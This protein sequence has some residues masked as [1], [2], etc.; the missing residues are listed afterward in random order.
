MTGIFVKLQWY[1][2]F[3]LKCQTCSIFKSMTIKLITKSDKEIKTITYLHCHNLKGNHSGKQELA[4]F[5]IMLTTF[6]SNFK[7]PVHI[8]AGFLQIAKC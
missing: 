4:K 2:C 7:S 5:C 3:K 6:S 8:L 1:Q